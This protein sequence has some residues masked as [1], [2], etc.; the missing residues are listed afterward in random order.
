MV[1][2]ARSSETGVGAEPGGERL[3]EA[4]TPFG[5]EA[6]VRHH[7]A[8]GGGPLRVRLPLLE[9]VV[10]RLHHTRDVAVGQIGGEHQIP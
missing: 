8:F 4:T 2:T 1:S 3:E 7:D 9:H 10:D 5:I 6:R